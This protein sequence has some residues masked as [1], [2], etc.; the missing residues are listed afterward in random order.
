MTD[1]CL[2]LIPSVRRPT[3]R[4]A[5][6]S[7]NPRGRW[8]SDAWH[9][10][11][12]PPARRTPPSWPMQWRAPR[13]RKRESDSPRDASFPPAWGHRYGTRDLPA[14]SRPGVGRPPDTLRSSAIRARSTVPSVLL[15]LVDSDATGGVDVSICRRATVS[16]FA[17]KQLKAERASGPSVAAP[18]Y[19]QRC[20]SPL[21]A[22]RPWGHA[23]R[24]DRDRT[25]SAPR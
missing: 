15:L 24:P 5:K 22:R 6:A 4:E 13:G 20:S 1:A 18:H 14:V 21:A 17:E 19:D 23:P 25:V 11:R 7:V 16:A 10:S 12:E 9:S 3:L 8:R 2:P